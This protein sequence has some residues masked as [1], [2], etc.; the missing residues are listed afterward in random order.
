[1]FTY[2]SN[3]G[4]LRRLDRSRL[5]RILEMHQ[6]CLPP[7][8]AALL[9]T[10]MSY[11][12]FCDAWAAQFRAF[13]TLGLPLLQALSDI[14]TLA[15]HDNRTL[16]D[17]A[18]SNLPPEYEINPNFSPLHQALRLWLL[19]RADLGVPWPLPTDIPDRSKIKNHNSKIDSLVTALESPAPAGISPQW[20]IEIQNSRI[21]LPDQSRI[22]NHPAPD[23]TSNADSPIAVPADISDQSKIEIQNSKIPL[24]ALETA[25]ADISPQSKIETQSSKINLPALETSNA[26]SAIALAAD[27][28]A[29]SKIEIQNSKIT[30]PDQSTAESATALELSNADSPIAV[31]EISHESKI[32][33]QN[34]K[35]TDEAEIFD[36][37][38]I[39]NLQSKITDNAP[40]WPDPITDAPA[41]F[42]AV[43][44]RFT[45]YIWLPAGAPAVNSLFLGHCHAFPAFHYTPRLNIRSDKENSGKTTTMKVIASMAP[46]PFPVHNLRPPVVYRVTHKCQPR[47]PTIL[48]DEIENY[49]SLYRELLGLLNAGNSS[50]VCVP[51]CEGKTVHI[52][53]PFA[54]VVL[55]G[56]GDL[57]RTLRSRSI[58]IH[59]TE[60]PEDAKLARF[61]PGHLEL[62]TEL[63][64]K[65]ARWAADNLKQIAACDPPLP[66][67]ARNRLADN[68]RPLFQI[69]HVIGG[70]WPQLALEAFEAMTSTP[71]AKAEIEDV[72]RVLLGDIRRVLAQSGPAR[73]T[74]KQLIA[75]LTTLLD[76][77][78]RSLLGSQPHPEQ[79]LSSQ[80]RPLG[81]RSRNLW[82]HGTVLRGYLRSDF[83]PASPPPPPPPPSDPC[84]D[85]GI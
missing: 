49:L 62:E 25:P 2:F 69:A 55:A 7:E 4:I 64:R 12:Q 51:R 61:D 74:S 1:M 40:P 77:P 27:V 38:K 46:R 10:P 63:R 44:G 41:L 26:D 59:M 75:S 31:T 54:P 58:L 66:K 68:W 56:I 65:L 81:I 32:Q 39:E 47:P 70:H 85:P 34:S 30:F 16:L 57:F 3:P 42:D 84:F 53:K 78:W 79:W 50:D 24:P 73:L 37:S 8:A 22:E 9:R 21:T 52:Y 17:N 72:G 5:T 29:Q 6:D 14:E 19:T 15:L 28:S 60:A 43:Y 71:V 23:E 20:K 18:L 76:R 80:L 13:N 35:I 48:F 83:L 82:T 45:A 36:Q 33:N 67:T 11:E